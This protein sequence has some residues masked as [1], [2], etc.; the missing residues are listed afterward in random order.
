MMIN[1]ITTLAPIPIMKKVSWTSGDKLSTHCQGQNLINESNF[2]QANVSCGQYQ[3]LI[4]SLIA[5]NWMDFVPIDEIPNGCQFVN[6]LDDPIWDNVAELSGCV[7]PMIFG[8]YLN[9]RLEYSK[10]LMTVVYTMLGKDDSYF[11]VP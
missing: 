8:R 9:R 4:N 11:F 6:L 10:Y 5:S 2:G 1:G 3:A 7:D